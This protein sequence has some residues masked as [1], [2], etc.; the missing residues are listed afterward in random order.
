MI[1]ADEVAV[2]GP[3]ADPPRRHR[4]WWA[5]VV[6]AVGVAAIVV[7]V[8]ARDDTDAPD[9]A[10]VAAN[11][12]SED[13]ATASAL[14]ERL[15]VLTSRDPWLR[16]FSSDSIW[17]TPI[18]SEAVYVHA[19]LPHTDRHALEHSTLMRTDPSDP[20][21]AVLRTG[22]WRDRCSGTEDSGRTL[23]LPDGWA[24]PMVTDSATPNNPGVFLLPDGRTMYNLG[25]M[26]RCS[27]SGP[28][29]AQWPGDEA[30]AVTDLYGD[31]R[32]GAHGGSNLN[33]LGGAIRPDELTGD[34]PIRHA[35]DLLVWSEHLAWGGSKSNSYR[36]PATT[37]D[38]YAAADTYR[39]D[40][41]DLQM[42][43]LLALPP[44]VTAD[45]LGIETAVGRRLF[46]ALQDYGAYVTDDSAWDA[47]YLGVDSAAIGTF[48]WG[49]AERADMARMVTALHVVANNGPDSVGGGGQPR[50]P[51]LP[52]LTEPAEPA[53]GAP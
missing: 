2:A 31:G 48:P 5:V 52:E 29:Y 17:N 25:A 33:Q 20:E 38:S 26:G 10:V 37:S 32:L 53:E 36:W 14:A 16:P 28:L 12:F 13:S 34:Q 4:R 22:S 50:V 43:S 3:A 41:P 27:G 9:E 21:R 11:D 51:L 15:S 24:P 44:D 30:A 49:D 1:A 23:H 47:T 42:G 7:A 6:L 45:Q 35:L 39:G 40:V 8:V 18:G 46:Q 19:E